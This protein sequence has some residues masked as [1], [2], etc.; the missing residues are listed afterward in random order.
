MNTT[1]TNPATG[2]D[3][4]VPKGT[5]ITLLPYVNHRLP[6]YWGPDADEFR[7]ERMLEA[8]PGSR[9]G[10][11]AFIPF[12][13]GPR[14]CIGSRF[15]MLEMKTVLATLVHSFSLALKPGATVVPKLFITMR[16]FPGLPMVLTKVPL[17][18]T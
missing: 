9:G 1:L 15:A 16:P 3:V 7:P 11:Y 14:S 4:P 2:A 8:S 18:A 10:G 6:Q 17:P 13:A 12:I 5:I